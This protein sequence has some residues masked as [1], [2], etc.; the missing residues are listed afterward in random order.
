MILTKLLICL[1]RRSGYSNTLADLSDEA[2]HTVT[3][4]RFSKRSRSRGIS[5]D[6]VNHAIRPMDATIS[7]QTKML[8][9]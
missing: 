8:A 5:C 1:I 7:N 2:F 9:M 6:M 3:L 4:A